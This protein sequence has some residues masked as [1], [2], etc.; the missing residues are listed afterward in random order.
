MNGEGTLTNK[1]GHIV[2]G[3]WESGILKNGKIKYINGDMYEGEVEAINIMS[4]FADDGFRKTGKGVMIYK[5]GLIYDGE[6]K[7][8]KKDGKG[9]MFYDTDFIKEKPP[10]I[11]K[12]Q[13]IYEGE[14]NNDV[15]KGKGVFTITE[16][17]ELKIFK[18]ENFETDE[19]IDKKISLKGDGKVIVS[20]N[21]EKDMNNKTNGPFTIEFH[22]G[23]NRH[24]IITPHKNYK[25]QDKVTKGVNSIAKGITEWRKS[26]QKRKDEK[27]NKKMKEFLD[28]PDTDYYAVLLDNYRIMN[29]NYRNTRS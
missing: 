12:F 25:L 4:I 18:S 6:W 27:Y 22:P 7:N 21:P 20:G 28:D 8:D 11:Y 26:R 9:I 17:N 29:E 19:M 10:S 15:P 2:E 5:N 14:W 13:A 23:D 24:G 16:K 3:N 1:D